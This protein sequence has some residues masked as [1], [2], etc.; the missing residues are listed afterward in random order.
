M[1]VITIDISK[2]PYTPPTVECLRFGGRVGGKGIGCCAIDIFQGFSN[3]PDAEA[4]VPLNN[5]DSPHLPVMRQ[6]SQAYLG[7]TNK[8]VFLGYLRLG[9]FDSMDLPNH[10][11]FCAISESQLNSRTTEKWLE[12]FKENGFEF[13]RAVDNSVYLNGDGDPSPVYIFALFRNIGDSKIDDPFEPPEFWKTLPEPS[14]S[15]EE[16][17]ASQSTNII[18]KPAEKASEGSLEAI[19]AAPSPFA[20]KGM[21][22]SA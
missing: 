13:L 12:I 20:S 19:K 6:G 5:G 1:S 22:A 9:T 16:R 21:K 4:Y 10:A 14:E 3:D 15:D 17:W 8:D 18:N 11:F 2:M 7:P